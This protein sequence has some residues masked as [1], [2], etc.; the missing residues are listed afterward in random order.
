MDKAASLSTFSNTMLFPALCTASTAAE[1]SLALMHGQGP[2][3]QVQ[4]ALILSRTRSD[5]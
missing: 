3:Q 4:S 2:M 5:V 1:P